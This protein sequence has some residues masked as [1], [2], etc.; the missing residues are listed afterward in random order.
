MN[1]LKDLYREY[2]LLAERADRAFADMQKDHGPCI[3]CG[4]GCSD[5][6]HSVF[7]LFL[8]ESV[9]INHHFHRLDRKAR[10]EAAPRLEKAD[11]DLL[12]VGKR[13]RAYDHDPGAKALAMARERVRCPLLN[14][15]EKCALYKYRPITCRVYGIPTVISGAVHACW[16]AGFEKA[17]PYPAFDLDG[18]YREL[19]GLSKKVLASFGQ[20]DMDRASLLVSVSKSIRTP[21][22]ELIKS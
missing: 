10:R 13:L 15:E 11:R 16:K 2:E 20:R 22:E 12:E 9:Y 5:C 14:S 19:Y 17:R 4:V 6:C 7:G 1:A 18:M 21:V 3:R 8:V